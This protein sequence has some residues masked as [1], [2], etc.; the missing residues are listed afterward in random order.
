MPWGGG[1][2]SEERTRGFKG[3]FSRYKQVSNL[4]G[5]RFYGLYVASAEVQVRH[6]LELGESPA[7]DQADGISEMF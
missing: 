6:E 1:G 2:G 5:P 3:S 4:Q 7:A